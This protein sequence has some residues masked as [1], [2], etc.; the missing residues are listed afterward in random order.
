MV[1]PCVSTPAEPPGCAMAQ[2]TQHPPGT[3]IPEGTP[4]PHPMTIRKRP[5]GRTVDT[6]GLGAGEC[7]VKPIVIYPAW[8]FNGILM[9][10]SWGFNGI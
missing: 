9:G 8:C 1:L 4:E 2:G 10:I 7:V 6:S 3:R 5:L